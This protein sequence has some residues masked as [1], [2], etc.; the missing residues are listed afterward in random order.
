MALQFV[1]LLF[2]R[3][4]D[5]VTFEKVLLRS[6]PIADCTCHLDCGVNCDRRDDGLHT[7]MGV[8]YLQPAL[9][10]PVLLTRNA[11]QQQST[12]HLNVH[13]SSC[14]H[15]DCKTNGWTQI[16]SSSSAA[17]QRQTKWLYTRHIDTRKQSK[18]K[19]NQ[20]TEKRKEG[21]QETVKVFS[22]NAWTTNPIRLLC[23]VDDC[24]SVWL[25]HN[26]LV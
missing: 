26:L 6:N 3:H 5:R 4:V 25:W 8:I 11:A 7:T 20:W 15:L 17:L 1:S 22:A 9:P 14:T 13:Y 19:S 12:E 10:L 2:N 21:M 24:L 18:Y 23:I 16:D